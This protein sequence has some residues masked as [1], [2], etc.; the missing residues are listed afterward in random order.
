MTNVEKYHNRIG[1]MMRPNELVLGERYHV[2]DSDG[3]WFI[4]QYTSVG[5]GVV[6]AHIRE[7]YPGAGAG[8]YAR[9][10]GVTMTTRSSERN[11]RHIYELLPVKAPISYDKEPQCKPTPVTDRAEELISLMKASEKV[12]KL[13][14]E[15]QELTAT[16][17]K[18]NRELAE[19]QAALD[20]ARDDLLKLS[21]KQVTKQ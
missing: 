9:G 18:A 17:E 7:G 14:V 8:C 19:R 13:A 11:C 5:R 6:V 12:G 4:A 15:V 3:E 20:T 1:K 2:M 10:A 16:T 21:I